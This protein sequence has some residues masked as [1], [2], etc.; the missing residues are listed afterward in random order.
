[1][2]SQRVRH[3]WATSTFSHMYTTALIAREPLHKMVCLMGLN[4]QRDLLLISVHNSAF[5]NLCVPL[6]ILTFFPLWL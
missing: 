4:G 2:G 6:Q 5:I 1:M 3:D